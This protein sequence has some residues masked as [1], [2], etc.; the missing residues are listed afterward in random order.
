MNH[1]IFVY[2]QNLPLDFRGV[3]AACLQSNVAEAPVEMCIL[4]GWPVLD[5]NV[6]LGSHLAIKQEWNSLLLAS[7]SHQG[8]TLDDSL[9]FLARWCGKLPEGFQ[10]KM[11]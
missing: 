10:F 11:K 1:I 4:S 8:Q 7:R 9:K 3:Y 6:Q 2:L 5:D